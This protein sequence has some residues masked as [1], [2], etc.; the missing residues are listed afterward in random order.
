ML[1]RSFCKEVDATFTMLKLF[2]TNTVNF[3][4]FKQTIFVNHPTA[5][6][7]EEITSKTSTN[8]NIT[9]CFYSKEQVRQVFSQRRIG[10]KLRKKILFLKTNF[11][12][13]FFLT[14]LLK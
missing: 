10:L 11:F 9:W 6:R 4:P 2:K 8:V 14:E 7:R 12:P 5:L 13:R 1:D 3:V